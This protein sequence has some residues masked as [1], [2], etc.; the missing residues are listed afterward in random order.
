[1]NLLIVTPLILSCF[2]TLDACVPIN[3]EML[4]NII[5]DDA[6]ITKEKLHNLL[7]NQLQIYKIPGFSEEG[8]EQHWSALAGDNE[9]AT[10]THL[11]SYIMKIINFLGNTDNTHQ[12]EHKDDDD[13][14]KKNKNK[15][16]KNKNK[17]KKNKN[18]N[19][20]NN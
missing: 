8:F 14:K 1:M 15:N 7:K 18:K 9:T 13:E 11:A 20:K 19:K 17:N 16:K 5:E 12:E 10:K 4:C 3:G 2:G 6:E